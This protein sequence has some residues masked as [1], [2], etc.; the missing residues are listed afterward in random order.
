M[1]HAVLV[2][3]FLTAAGPALADCDDTGG[4]VDQDE[5]CDGDGW[6]RAEGDCD[7]LEFTVNPSREE[8]CDD[9][10]DNDCNGY[11]NDG[12]E[13]TLDRGSL[14]GGSTCWTGAAPS[15][16]WASL[17]LLSVVRRRRS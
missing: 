7:D 16:W 13:D 10:F 2:A 1:R 3:L 14:A 12:C 15:A 5:D 9:A 6:T 11:F 8:V 17:L 4:P